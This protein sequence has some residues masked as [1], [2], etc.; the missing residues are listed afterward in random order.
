MYY[1]LLFFTIRKHLNAA[2]N[3]AFEINDKQTVFFYFIFLLHY[4][5]IYHCRITD[6]I[7]RLQF[8]AAVKSQFVYAVNVNSN[9]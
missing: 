2:R 3:G 5:N 1:I 8:Y 6:S 4:K 7:S 9:T